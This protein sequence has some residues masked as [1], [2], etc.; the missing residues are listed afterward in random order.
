M[1]NTKKLKLKAHEPQLDEDEKNVAYIK[2]HTANDLITRVMK[3]IYMLKKPIGIPLGKRNVIQPF[4]DVSPIEFI[5]QKNECPLFLFTSHS[6]KRPNNLV[7]GR[8]FD[9]GVLD[10][11]EFGVEHYKAI[12]DFPA[13]ISL[14][15]K[16]IMVFAG[17]PFETDFDMIRIKSLL[18]DFFQGPRPSS[19]RVKGIEH[20]ILFTA[21]GG[22]IYMRPYLVEQKKMTGTDKLAAVCHDMGPQLDL[23]VR[24]TRIADHE[25]FTEACKQKPKAPKSTKNKNISKDE[26]G[27]KHGKIHIGRQD[28]GRMYNV[29]Y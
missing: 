20:V 8:L 26:L 9:G 13:R 12:E 15:V 3:D 6:K 19:L 21:H 17:E 11:I 18:N 29:K 2:G 16:P 27:T 28:F 14:G 23:V 10:M 22:K 5:C 1:P 4:E 25:H 7:M 24:R